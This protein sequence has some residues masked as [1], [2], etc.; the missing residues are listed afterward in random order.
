MIALVDQQ[1]GQGVGVEFHPPA[2]GRIG[3]H[4]DIGDDGLAGLAAE[5]RARTGR[6]R[7]QLAHHLGHVLVVD[8]AKGL[9]SREIAAGEEVEVVQQG[10][11]GRVEPVLVLELER[12][13]LRH[14]T[15][16]DTGRLE[17]LATVEHRLHP[18]QVDG[19]PVR[20]LVQFAPQ[21]AALVH[22][23]DE[24]EGDRVF[25]RGEAGQSG[26]LLQKVRQ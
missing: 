18:R 2:A 22:A 14:R 23:V 3:P 7:L 9:Q 17:T 13:T 15:G 8:A 25:R 6:E 16:H 10:L 5:G 26:L 24:G 20:D 21:I 1:P 11:H 12:Q 4:E 19:Q